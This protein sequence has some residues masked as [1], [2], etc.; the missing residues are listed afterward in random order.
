MNSSTAGSSRTGHG[1][2]GGRRADNRPRRRLWLGAS[3]LLALAGLACTSCSSATTAPATRTAEAAPPGGTATVAY[4]GSLELLAE[5]VLGPQFERATSDNY[6]GRGAG[7]FGL[8]HE[9]LSGEISPNVF[10]SVGAAPIALLE[11]HIARFAVALAT[12]PLVVAY[13]AHTKYAAELG[14]IAKGRRPLSALFSLLAEPG[15]TL[16]RTN[17][18]TDPQGQAF[19]MMIESA[20]RVLHLP[21]G[22]AA[23][24]LGT[25]AANPGGNAS[26]I[27]SETGIL[28]RLEAGELD[29]SSAF[30][31]EAI[32]YHLPYISLPPALNFGDP[33]D[34]SLY[35]SSVLDVSGEK[36]VHGSLLVLEATVINRPPGLPDP[37]PSNERAAAS[38]LA[39]LL[40]PVARHD[41][42][43]AGYRL[44]PPVLEGMRS[45]APRPVLRA[46]DRL[47]GS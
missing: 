11:P 23:R 16:G 36:P 9:I 43:A 31:S 14:A 28:P 46:I 18:A 44:V 30:A 24:I 27:F 35:R 6:L 20:E 29:A 47:Q 37:S 38:F 41:F 10:I 2:A 34:S 42:A 22:E 15:F 8:A 19:E 17:P 21:P 40:S 4:A 32:Q 33:A 25:S 39:F 5:K 1:Q 7:S 45:A 12:T 3:A 26:Q 13:S